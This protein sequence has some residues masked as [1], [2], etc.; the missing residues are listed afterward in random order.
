MDPEGGEAITKRMRHVIVGAGA[1]GVNAAEALVKGGAES[2]VIVISKDRGNPFSPV[3]LPD[4]IEGKVSKKDVELWDRAFL[5][6]S[7]IQLLSG[8]EVEAIRAGSQKVKLDNGSTIQYDRL[9]VASGASP[10]V[11][12]ELAKR[13]NLFTLRSL[14]DAERIMDRVRKSALVYGAGPVAVKISVALRRIGVDVMVLCR[15]RVLRRLFDEDICSRINCLLIENGVRVEGFSMEA[16]TCMLGEPG[17]RKVAV[18]FDD[19]DGVIAALGVTPNTSFLDANEM[20]LGP[21][22]G[23]V[24][25]ERMATSC[26]GVYAAGD[27]AETLDLTTGKRGVM[28]LW[29][30]AVE[31]GKVAASNMI[32]I[33]AK[34]KG[35]V[36]SNIVDVF[37]TPFVSI[38]SLRGERVEIMRRDG[39]M[40]FT[41]AGNRIVGCQLVNFQDEM[42]IIAS[43]VSGRVG[44]KELTE[45]E[46]LPFGKLADLGPKLT[47]AF[48]ARTT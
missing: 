44:I 26:K 29:Q 37:G 18:N 14:E 7:G 39:L 9:L 22:G 28:A 41:V 42:G 19:Y 6:K 4:F 8:R 32:G 17:G 12:G 45:A 33:E 2:E 48:A 36:P 21:S 15:S 40:R 25:D 27:C 5:K 13:G 34:Y 24:T 11:T 47:K 31:Q 35:G 46:L 38:G 10:I 1:A 3:A 23:M 43:C 16:G 20:A 30:L